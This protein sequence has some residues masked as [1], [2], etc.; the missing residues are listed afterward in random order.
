[1]A[2]LT[3]ITIVFF[4][5]RLIGDRF[6]TTL[7]PMSMSMLDSLPRFSLCLLRL[8]EILRGTF[9]LMVPLRKSVLGLA[10]ILP[11]RREHD[12]WQMLNKH[13]QGALLLLDSKHAI[14][15]QY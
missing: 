10:T 1:V 6:R 3:A 12:L 2:S 7:G 14:G 4:P 11:H 8:E 13:G 5:Q 15:V 9:V